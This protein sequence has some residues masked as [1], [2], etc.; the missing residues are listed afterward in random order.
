VAARRLIAVM[1]VLLFL[2]SLAA[3]LAPVERRSEDTSTSTTDAVTEPVAQQG[4]LVEA[5]I[6]GAAKR[7]QRVRA[8]VGDQLQLRVTSERVATVELA[9]LGPT[10]D[11]DPV[12]PALFDVLLPEPGRYE[13]RELGGKGEVYGTIVVSRPAPKERDR[14]RAPA[15]S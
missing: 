15:R 3:A 11:V 14:E 4:E 5:T 9:G 7:P 1:L 12:A 10:E 8:H 2:S 13:V 6:D